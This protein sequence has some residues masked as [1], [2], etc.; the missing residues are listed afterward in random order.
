MK[1]LFNL[2]AKSILLVHLEESVICS[3]N[4]LINYAKATFWVYL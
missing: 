2:G 4:N 3:S 1:I